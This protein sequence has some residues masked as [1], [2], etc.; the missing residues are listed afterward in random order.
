MGDV[1]CL[2]YDSILLDG[3]NYYVEFYSKSSQYL[4]FVFVSEFLFY[5]P[6]VNARIFFNLSLNGSFGRIARLR[7]HF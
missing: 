2:E 5:G 6:K 4:H 1:F 7:K 3:G